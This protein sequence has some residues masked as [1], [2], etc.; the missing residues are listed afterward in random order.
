[1]SNPFFER[2]IVN[3][4][5]EYPRQHWELDET[6][7]PPAGVGQV[8]FVPFVGIAPRRYMELF[9]MPLRKTDDGL[10]ITWN[11]PSAAPRLPESDLTYLV[12]E[13]EE[14]GKLQVILEQ[15]KDALS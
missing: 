3:S 15:K 5:Y 7:Q 2:P 13:R 8:D 1:M 9:S 12:R 14:F 10:A 6:G 4:P 11:A